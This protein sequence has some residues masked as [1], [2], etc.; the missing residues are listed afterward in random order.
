MA[1]L[2]PPAEE[3]VDAIRRTLRAYDEPLLREVAQKLCRPRNQWPADELVERIVAALSNPVVLDRRLKELPAACRQLLALIGH[4][5]QPRWPVGSLVEM[6]IALGHADGLA[7]VIELLGMGLLQPEL[8]GAGDAEDGSPRIRL[9][10][11]EQWLSLSSGESPTVV[12]V[13]LAT[14]RVLGENLDLPDLQAAEQ[15]GAGRATTAR[16]ADGLEWPLRLAVLRQQVAAAPLRRTQQRDFFKRDL[17]RLQGDAL[18]SAPVDAPRPIA[19]PALLAVSLGLAAG[20]L[21]E[22]DAEITA[23]D[24]PVSWQESL[25]AVL[26]E[27]WTSLPLVRGWELAR[28]WQPDAGAANPTASA[29]LLALLLLGRLPA[30][31]WADADAIDTWLRARHPYWKAAP[32]EPTGIAAF[33]LGLAFAL[34]L[35]EARPTA[36]DTWQVRLTAIGRWLLGLADAAPNLASF[37]QTVLVQPNLEILAYRQGLTPALI[38]A[39]SHFADWKSLGPACTLQLEPQSVYRGLEAGETFTSIVQTLERHGMKALPPAVLDSLRTWSNK[40]E[41]ITVY[42]AAALFEFATAAE[43]TEAIQRGLPAQRLTDRLAAVASES[44]IDFRHFRLTGTRDYLLPPERCVE[45]EPDGVTLQ[46]D[47]VRSDLILEIEMQRFAESV[48][49]PG[50][51]GRRQYRLTPES[52]RRAREQGV[53][54][55]LLNRWFEQRTGAGLPPAARMLLSVGEGAP[56]ELRREVVLHVAD[57]QVADGLQQWPGT[58]TLIQER[59]GPTALAVAESDIATLIERLRELGMYSEP[60]A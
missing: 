6:L 30:G 22:R 56:P 23:G 1:N 54:A 20:V 58:R 32:K 50:S 26:A 59:L 41:R 27:L 39:L 16:E 2:M 12:A 31:A 35:V 24:F 52:L 44:A 28:G 4:S 21:H 45:V 47:L 29:M 60:P 46:I 34:R 14:T 9:K 13:R 18:L 8:P 48:A 49:R 11:F 37:P 43:L 5:R 36:D 7:P 55:A 3:P 17:E 57:P 19:D 38:I 51:A 33:L 15:R 25:P 10:S 53:S 40:R 42:A